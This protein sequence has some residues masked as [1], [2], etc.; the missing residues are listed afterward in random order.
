MAR[1]KRGLVEHHHEV[2]E[3]AG[4]RQRASY[5]VEREGKV[6]GKREERGSWSSVSIN[7]KNSINLPENDSSGVC[8][9]REVQTVQ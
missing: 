9:R 7:C 5:A 1:K 2:D 6:S 4:D 3:K 8:L